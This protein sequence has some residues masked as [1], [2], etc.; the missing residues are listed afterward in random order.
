MIGAVA[1]VDA[2]VE[3]DAVDAVDETAQEREDIVAA[4]ATVAA[5][6]VVVEAISADVT[7]SECTV[8]ICSS[9]CSSLAKRAVHRRSAQ[10]N[11]GVT[12]AA[13]CD[14]S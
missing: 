8:L 4:A 7:G 3:L 12:P 13:T 9:N 1:A 14:A 5:A 11:D 2:V 6:V 10:A